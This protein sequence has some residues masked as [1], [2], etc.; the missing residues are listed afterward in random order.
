MTEMGEGTEM[1][2]TCGFSCCTHVEMDA[3]TVDST[4]HPD[5]S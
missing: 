5:I 2:G 4:F 1:Q 3:K